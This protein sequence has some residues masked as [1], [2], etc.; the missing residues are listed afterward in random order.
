MPRDNPFDSPFHNPVTGNLIWLGTDGKG[1]KTIEDAYAARKAAP[2]AFNTSGIS[3]TMLP[4]RVA[5]YA[6]IVRN[7]HKQLETEDS[8]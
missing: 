4:E 3:K 6:E 1:A 2:G 5:R 7:Y 8:K